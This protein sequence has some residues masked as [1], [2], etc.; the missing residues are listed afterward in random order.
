VGKG[1][2]VRKYRRYNVTQAN[3]NTETGR[4]A[5]YKEQRLRVKVHAKDKAITNKGRKNARTVYQTIP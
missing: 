4:K 2:H 1:N 3:D 5:I